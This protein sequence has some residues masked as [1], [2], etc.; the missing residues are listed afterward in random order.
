MRRMF[1]HKRID[2]ALKRLERQQLLGSNESLFSVRSPFRTEDG[3]IKF[4]LRDRMDVEDDEGEGYLPEGVE[5]VLEIQVVSAKEQ[6]KGHGTRLMKQFLNLPEVK[7]VDAIFLDPSP[8]MESLD[9]KKPFAGSEEP[10]AEEDIL[11]AVE[12][13]Y[14]RL[15]FRNRS[16]HSRMWIF[17]SARLPFLRYPV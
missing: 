6:G 14:H 13:F 5:T 3:E 8:L 1:P 17:R 11:D 15:G 7:A 9:G 4:V 10:H 12:N 2:A 16:T